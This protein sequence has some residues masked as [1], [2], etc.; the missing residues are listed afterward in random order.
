MSIVFST[1]QIFIPEN[2]TKKR[3]LKL[4]G[5]KAED[6]AFGFGKS[7]KHSEAGRDVVGILGSSLRNSAAPAWLGEELLNVRSPEMDI[8]LSLSPNSS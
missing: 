7:K 6:V 2:A 8:P 3:E 5:V 4:W 1:L